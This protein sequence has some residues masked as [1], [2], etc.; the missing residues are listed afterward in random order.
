VQQVPQV[1][2]EL[3]QAEG[4]QVLHQVLQADLVFF[5]AAVAAV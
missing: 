1:D 5:Q 4:E 3:Q 2:L